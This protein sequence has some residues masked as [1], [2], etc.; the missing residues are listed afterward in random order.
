MPEWGIQ[1]IDGKH[2]TLRG[3]DY[4]IL[5]SSLGVGL[6]VFSAGSLLNQASFVDA[7]LAIIVGSAGGSILLALAG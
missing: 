4:F 2:K 7:I 6:L 5:W 1:P 3:L